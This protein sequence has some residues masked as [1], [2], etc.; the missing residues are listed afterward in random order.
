MG[1]IS[2]FTFISLD[3]YYKD[4]SDDISWHQHDAEGA[5]FSEDSLSNGNALLFGRKTYQLMASFWPSPAAHDAFPAVAEGMNKAKKFV[6]SN[7]LKSVDWANTTIINGDWIKQI[8]ELKQTL[9]ITI[10][11]SGSILSQLAER[12]LIDYFQ[13]MIDPLVLG[14]GTAIFS[15]IKEQINLRLSDSHVFKSGKILL[16]YQARI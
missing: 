10:L 6:I 4:L 3:G 9:N 7:S 1:T 15:G 13:V 8:T 11:G 16:N 5:K 12:G 2:S 14:A